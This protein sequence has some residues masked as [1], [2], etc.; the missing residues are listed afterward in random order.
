MFA[1]VVSAELVFLSVLVGIH[2]YFGCQLSWSLCLLW[3]S[4]EL[5]FMCTLVVSW[6]GLYVQFICQLSWSSTD[7]VLHRLTEPI[8]RNACTVW[9]MLIFCLSV[10]SEEGNTVMGN[11]NKTCFDC[12]YQFSLYIFVFSMLINSDRITVS[13]EMEQWKFCLDSPSPPTKRN[14]FATAVTFL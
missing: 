13:G 7:S 3:L 12:R 8:N 11:R 6:A 14:I 4:A 9:I 10:W 5:V 2:V 1:L